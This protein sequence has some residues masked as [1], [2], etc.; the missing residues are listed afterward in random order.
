M[1]AIRNG[2]FTVY[3]LPER[4]KG[5][6]GTALRIVSSPK[7]AITFGL[8]YQ[9]FQDIGTTNSAHV[10]LPYLSIGVTI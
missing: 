8:N 1:Y 4:Q 10:F 3:N 9:T 7:S 6:F 5:G 2:G